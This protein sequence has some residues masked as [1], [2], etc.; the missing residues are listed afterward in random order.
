MRTTYPFTVD[1]ILF[2]HHDWALFN[3]TM[4]NILDD[5]QERQNYI[6]RV[7]ERTKEPTPPAGTLTFVYQNPKRQGTNDARTRKKMDRIESIRD[8]I[9]D[10]EEFT[11]EDVMIFLETQNIRQARNTTVRDLSTFLNEGWLTAER[12]GNGGNVYTV[13]Q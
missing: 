10:Q 13:K 8:W 7:L 4:S 11:V 2:Q 9:S 1:D 12:V 6:A 5:S 3:R